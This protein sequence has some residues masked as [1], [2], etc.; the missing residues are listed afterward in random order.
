MKSVASSARRG[1]TLVELLMV[2]TIIGMLMALLVAGA[3]KAVN[4]AKIARITVE[5]GMLDTAV[6]NYKNEI[7]G[8]YPPDCTFLGTT[9]GP[10]P[11]PDWI[12]ARNN[13]IV[14][15]LRK[16]FPRF[17]VG[18]YGTGSTQGT[19]QYAMQQ[20]FAV[21]SQA[22]GTNPPNGVSTWGDLN[23]LDAAEALVF[24]LGGPPGPPVLNT[25]TNT[26][27]YR[28]IG[29]ASNKVGNPGGTITTANQAQTLG[30]FSLD[31]KSRIKGPFE[32]QDQRLGDADGDG[33]PEYYPAVDSVP[34]P[35]GSTAATPGNATAPYVYFD[36]GSYSA[37]VPSAT[38]FT[39]YPSTGQYPP[40]SGGGAMPAQPANNYQGLWGAATPYANAYNAA[41]YQMTWMNTDKFQ[42]ISA[43][44]DSQYYF[45]ST[46]DAFRVFPSGAN[47]SQADMDNVANFSNGKLQD[48]IP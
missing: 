2:I 7:G 37:V 21:S 45:G 36:G 31:A 35:T 40:V 48:S 10:A 12:G 38:S 9:A 15:H 11:T 26:W 41:T 39:S 34:Q 22:Y 5:V 8:A 20:A 1:F 25:T 30:P 29:F 18:G 28:V 47:Y 23:N 46:P 14:A 24:W 42:I 44:L 4:T 33:W 13:R 27:S 19:L 6:Q 43:G 32:F 16:A 3:M 17:Y